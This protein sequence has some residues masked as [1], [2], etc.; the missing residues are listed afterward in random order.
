MRTVIALLLLGLAPLVSAADDLSRR[1]GTSDGWV[2]W[3]VPRIAEAG[4]A[5]CHSFRGKTM[6]HRGCDLDG[7]QWNVRTG[8]DQASG[9]PGNLIVYAHLKRGAVDKIRAFSASCPVRTAE[10]LRQIETVDPADSVKWLAA[11]V[12]TRPGGKDDDE[13]VAAVAFH[14]T[15]AAMTAL[16]EF[17]GSGQPEEQRKAALFWMGQSRGADGVAAVERY[18]REDADA[19]VREHAVFVL[20]QADEHG[21][22]PKV[23]AI[24]GSDRSPK[25]RGQSLFWLAQMEDRRAA[26]DITAALQRE[27]DPDVREQGVFALSQLPDSEGDRALIALVRGD[28]P[29]EIKQKALFWLG[30]S[31]SDEAIAFLDSVLH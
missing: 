16:R 17:A 1:I 25:V 22:Y 10:A 31:G 18:A 7:R 24:A 19:E 23:L 28:F 9:D 30:Q 8:A 15:P 5:C 13:A 6:E 20:S 26:A 2:S 3:Q 4:D 12:K 14:A 11:Q 27:Q 29:R 21:T